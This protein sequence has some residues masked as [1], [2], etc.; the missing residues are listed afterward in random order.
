MAEIGEWLDLIGLG[1]YRAVFARNDID[2]DTLPELTDADLERLGLSLGHRKRLLRALA[3][4]AG[5]GPAPADAPAIEAAPTG[6]RSERIESAERR[7]LTV[8][9]C[10]LVGSTELSARLDPEELRA[11]VRA[12]QETAVAVIARFEGHVA[13]Y[14]GDGLLTYFGYPRAHEDDAQRAVRAGLGIVEAI[15]VLNHR[16]DQN[17]RVALAVRIGIHT[18]LAVVGEMGAGQRHEQLALGETPNVAARLQAQA[19]PNC[20]LIGGVTRRLISGTFDLESLGMVSVKGLPGPVPAWRVLGESD[21]ESRFAAMRAPSRAGIIGREA[22]LAWLRDK[23]DRVR[24][25]HGQ[26]VLVSGEAGI[27][28]SRLAEAFGEEIGATP[29]LRLHYQSSLYHASSA[30]YPVIRHIERAAGIA[31]VTSPKRKLGRLRA[32]L[33][34]AGAI[35]EENVSAIAELL[36][37]APPEGH[38]S[39]EPNPRRRK[40]RALA[41]L[42]DQLTR[43]ARRQPILALLEDAHWIDRTTQELLD[44]LLRPLADLPVLLLITCRPE[45]TPSWSGR[46]HVT[47]LSLSRLDRQESRAMIRQ[48]AG[49]KSLP[50]QVLDEILEKSDGVALF[51]EELTR[52]V[53][54]SG[55]LREDTDCWHLAAPLLPRTIPPTLQDSLMARLDRLGWAKEIAQTAAALGREF[56]GGL[57]GAV[58]DL[59]PE[60]LQEG[61]QRIT[62]AGLLLRRGLDPEAT[63]TFKHALVQD[64]AY[65]SLLHSRRRVLHG[66]IAPVLE[67]RFAATAEVLPEVVARH[68]TEARLPRPALTWWHKAGRRSV[69]QSANLDAIGQ[70]GQGIALLERL[71]DGAERDALELDLRI[72]LGV[73]LSATAGYTAPEWETN[74]ARLLELHERTGEIAKLF[75]VLWGQWVGTFSAGKMASARAMAE[76]I[77]HVA[78]RHDDRVFLMLGHRVLGMSLVGQA[79]LPLARAHLERAIE[80]YD[81]ERDPPLAYIYAVDQRISAM[82]YL[83]IALLQLGHGDQAT[84]LMEQTIAEAKRLDASNT[85]SFALCLAVCFHVLGRDPIHLACTANE[86]AALSQRYGLTIRELMARTVMAL[87]DARQEATEMALGEIRRG[88][89]ELQALNWGFWTPWLML[90]EVEIHIDRGSHGAA[91]TLLEDVEALIEPFSYGLCAPELHR[92]RARA[93]LAEGAHADLVEAQ[94]K[95]STDLA[96]RQS[97]RLAE[98]CATTDL[99]CLWREGGRREQ[100]RALLAPILA[101]FGDGSALADAVRAREVLNSLL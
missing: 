39:V 77:L 26:A 99:A 19:A 51:V 73:A 34:Q 15:R 47:W 18:G 9:F 17:L 3:E 45:F 44:R 10:D 74:S 1:H 16:L 11:V 37:I 85:T 20:V 25:G 21:A 84:L 7:Q 53:L 55:L 101:S 33:R 86:T 8:M 71:P 79:E 6:A 14:L 87:L 62:E 70:L 97:A 94:L 43:L 83:A 28:K 31:L 38:A 80:L 96:R 22:E 78:E 4:I 40:V 5:K 36:S 56:S 75:P 59:A 82:S 42:I 57:L 49:E 58:S 68:Y 63:Y 27:G 98:L 88:I 95:R 64:A 24:S 54:E 60:R 69:H 23:W 41:A 90:M 91:R 76:R 66:R 65:A 12:Y 92:L 89:E 32:L 72:D 48:V 61:L 35:D 29:H 30:L 67:E 52:A 2:A 81:P 100:A 50:P 93:L 13:Q 46:D